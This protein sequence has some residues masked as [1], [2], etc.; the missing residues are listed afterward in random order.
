MHE[1][2]PSG[3]TIPYPKGTILAPVTKEQHHCIISTWYVWWG[4][5]Q[6][7]RIQT[8]CVRLNAGSPCCRIHADSPLLPVSDAWQLLAKFNACVLKIDEAG[9][10][11]GKEEVQNGINNTCWFMEVL[12]VG[13]NN[14][15]TATP[16]RRRYA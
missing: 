3:C 15:C 14:I 13:D 16:T 12:L 6:S 4:S 1:G 5:Q 7:N 8:K 10:T 11:N 2:Y 9:Q